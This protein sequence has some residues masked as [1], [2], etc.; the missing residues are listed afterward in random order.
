MDTIYILTNAC[1]PGLVKI[2]RTEDL[3]RRLKEL[4]RATG[5]PLPF[6]CFFACTVKEGDLVESVFTI[7][8]KIKG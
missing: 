8:S 4:Y 2:G 1:M 5:T 7:F 3:D 6:E